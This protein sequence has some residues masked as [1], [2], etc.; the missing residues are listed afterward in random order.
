MLKPAT[1]LLAALMLLA[2]R[3]DMADQQRSKTLGQNH[4]FSDGGAS[5]PLPVDTIPREAPRE[6]TPFYTGSSGGQLLQRLPVGLTRG[7]LERGRQRFDIF[8]AVC[9]GA[10]GYGDGMIVQRGFPPPPSFHIERLRSAPDGHFFEVIT[11]G[12]GLM[13]PYG[14]RVAP[15]DRWAI[16]AYIRTLQL[17]Q[18]A[19]IDDATPEGRKQLGAP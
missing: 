10:G 1:A 7:L 3:R 19:T 15:A 14:Y 5:R 9:H 8:C 18:N 13:Y 2:C 12:Y 11:R 17:S 4:F 6:E 16:T